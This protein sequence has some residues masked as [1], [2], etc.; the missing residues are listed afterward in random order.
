MTGSE[1]DG[2]P[3][4]GL[5]TENP[6]LVDSWAARTWHSIGHTQERMPEIASRGRIAL[7]G[8]LVVFG[9]LALFG[10]LMS[11]V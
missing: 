5:P 9:A 3:N 11:L 6:I 4:F 10:F 7:I 8:V 2:P 1:H